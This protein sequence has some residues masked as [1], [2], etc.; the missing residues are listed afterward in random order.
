MVN[1]RT[2]D[3]VIVEDVLGYLGLGCHLSSSRA[4]DPSRR[5]FMYGDEE[6]V[7]LVEKIK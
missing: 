1:Y 6:V 2:G 4:Q 5:S 7:L 3:S